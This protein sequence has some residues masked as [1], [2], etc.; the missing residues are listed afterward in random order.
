[1]TFNTMHIPKKELIVGSYYEGIES[2]TEGYIQARWNGKQFRYWNYSFGWF[3]DRIELPE[4]AGRFA[5][6]Y[7][8]RILLQEEIFQEIDLT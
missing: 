4:D 2:R 3:Q 5:A 6:F 7:P 1:M 8:K